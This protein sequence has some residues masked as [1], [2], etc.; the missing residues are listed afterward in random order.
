MPRVYQRSSITRA[1]LMKMNKE[2]HS[3][4]DHFGEFFLVFYHAG[5]S[6]AKKLQRGKVEWK[7]S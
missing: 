7:T 1:G 6:Y 2:T 5:A 3:E 4:T